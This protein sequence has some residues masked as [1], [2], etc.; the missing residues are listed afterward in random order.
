[1]VQQRVITGMNKI[2]L[3]SPGLFPLIKGGAENQMRILA[4]YFIGQNIDLNIVTLNFESNFDYKLKTKVTT[5]GLFQGKLLLIS[6]VMHYTLVRK[7]RTVIFSQLNVLTFFLIILTFNKNIYLRFSNS[8]QNFDFDRLFDGKFTKFK[9]YILKAKINYFVSIN[10]VITN[11]LN[12][13][14]FHN[15]IEI[16]NIVNVKKFHFNHCNFRLIVIGRYVEI[17]NLEFLPDLITLVPQYNIDVYGPKRDDFY[18]ISKVLAGTSQ[19]NICSEF[20]DKAFPFNNTKP[21][22]IHPSLVEGT[23]NA[24]LEALS[25]GV[26]VI[27]NNIPANAMFGS[28]GENGVFLISVNDKEKWANCIETLDANNVLYNK[29]SMNAKKYILSSHS[30]ETNIGKYWDAL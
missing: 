6:A 28:A 30:V 27:A 2:T 4:E 13:Y 15:V 24:I 19:I 9:M 10:P 14:G 22:L 18:R 20:I 29:I 11:H 25:F 3:V 5:I 8:Q 26:P 21:V 16:N 23:S 7:N 1:M 12:Q 17:K